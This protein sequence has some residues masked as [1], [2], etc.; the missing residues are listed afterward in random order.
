MKE[1]EQSTQKIWYTHV[2]EC[3]R[4][5]SLNVWDTLKRKHVAIPGL[6]SIQAQTR[7]LY[8]CLDCHLLFYYIGRF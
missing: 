7:P 1:D 3:P 2:K 8:E 4:C 6:S 5:Y